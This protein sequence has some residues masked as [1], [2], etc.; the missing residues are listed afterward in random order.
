MKTTINFTTP[1]TLFTMAALAVVSCLSACSKDDNNGPDQSSSAYIMATNTAEVSDAQDFYA[2]NNKVNN[3]ALAYSQSTAYV[4]VNAGSHQLQFKTSGSATV[5][6]SASLN[7]ENGKY[8]S[9]FYTDDKSTV[10]VTDD[11]TAPKSGKARVRFINLSSALNA[12]I[13]F[14]VTGGNKLISG[15]AYRAAS[16]YNEID[17]ATKFSLYLAGSSDIKL[18]IPVTIEAGHIYTIYISGA[19][20]ATLHYNLLVQD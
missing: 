19:T 18:D 15:L 1:K 11:H 14:G 17:A 16:A 9:V 12:A 10:T 7:T 5:N 4:K 8:Y 6:S 3:S 2:D 20:T 13:D